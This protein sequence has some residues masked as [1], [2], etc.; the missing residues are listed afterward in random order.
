MAW[1]VLV[2]ARAFWVSGGQAKAD[3]EA[4]GCAVLFSPEAGPLKEETLI[5]Q[6]QN[7]DAVIGSS[8]PYNASV[9]AACPHLKVVSRCG[10]GI[11]SVDTTAATAAGIL[12]TNTPGAM[13]ESV[14]DYTFALLLGIARRI[15]EGD[16]L[17][18]SGGWGEYPGAAVAGKTLGLVGCGQIGQAVAR[19]ASG[20]AMRVL[21]YDPQVGAQGLANDLSHV[22]FASLETVLQESDFVSLHAPNLPE[23]RNMFNAERFALM[24][25]TAYFINTARGALVDETALVTALEQGKIAGAATDVYQQEPLPADSPLRTAPRLLLTPHNAFNSVE[26]A[27][28][29]SRLSAVNVLSALQ[30]EV[31]YGLVNR[32][33][34]STPQLRLETLQGKN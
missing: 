9:F 22:Q 28:N 5:A 11:D 19:R 2:T 12:V 15:H 29:M 20:F 4:A 21:A 30:G 27:E 3:L 23:T 16:A 7:C 34:L 32:A 25:P 33:V 1:R 31:P 24:K 13:T 8:D 18:R 10:V 14:G 6:L 17:M 26:A